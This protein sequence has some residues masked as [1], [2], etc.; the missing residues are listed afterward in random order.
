[1]RVFVWSVSFLSNEQ[2]LH[3]RRRRGSEFRP[4]LGIGRGG[5]EKWR[6]YKVESSASSLDAVEENK[7]WIAGK[8]RAGDS[9]QSV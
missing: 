5:N 7:L 4:R 1:M 3:D 6:I 9:T 8:R 2:L